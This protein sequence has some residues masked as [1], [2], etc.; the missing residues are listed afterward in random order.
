MHFKEV[1]R[2]NCLWFKNRSCLEQM[3]AAGIRSDAP[4]THGRT[5]WSGG[6]VPYGRD[7]SRGFLGSAASTAAKRTEPNNQPEHRAGV[8]SIRNRGS[9]QGL[10]PFGTDS[11]A[12]ETTGTLLSSRRPRGALHAPSSS[13]KDLIHQHSVPPAPVISRGRMHVKPPNKCEFFFLRQ[14]LET[15]P[16]LS[17]CTSW[18]MLSY[19]QPIIRNA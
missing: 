15:L 17:L 6:Q 2:P 11:N 19:Y 8:R 4:S 9:S 12:G 1:N 14:R 13:A 7:E 16:A 10:A 5:L 3:R 18:L